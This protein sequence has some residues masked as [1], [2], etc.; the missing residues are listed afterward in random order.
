[1]ERAQTIEAIQAVLRSRDDATSAVSNE[2]TFA[3]TIFVLKRPVP[4]LLV[5]PGRPD[6]NDYSRVTF[7]RSFAR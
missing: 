4:E 2:A 1:M 3:S 6:L 7:T 5:A